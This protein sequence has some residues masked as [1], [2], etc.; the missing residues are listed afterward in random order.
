MLWSQAVL[1][2]R[3]EVG[4]AGIRGCIT[5]RHTNPGLGLVSLYV[6]AILD[7]P[8]PNLHIHLTY[9]IVM[10]QWTHRGATGILATNSLHSSLLS[11]FLKA[12][13]RCN[14]VHSFI[15][16]PHFFVSLP[17]F[18]PPGTV[19]CSMVFAS[20]DDLVTCPYYFSFWCLTVVRRSS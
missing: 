17:L 10:D 20:P 9:P 19:P 6:Y 5:Y 3:W 15:L 2:G 16:S 11:A 14:P 4:G 8:S 18:L 12:S 7:S 13:L 1:F